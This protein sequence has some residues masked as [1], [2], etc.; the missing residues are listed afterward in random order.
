MEDMEWIY[1]KAKIELNL[2]LEKV[3]EILAE[4]NLY[5][6]VGYEPREVIFQKL[7]EY[8]N[9]WNL[10]TR[11][12][13]MSDQKNYELEHSLELERMKKNYEFDLKKIEKSWSVNP[14]SYSEI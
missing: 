6:E 11:L 13:Q 4:L 14:I 2:D 9:N 7:V 8:T 1:E 10:N 3:T 5:N 12:T